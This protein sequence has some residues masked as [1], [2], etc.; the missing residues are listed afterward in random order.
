[1]KSSREALKKTEYTIPTKNSSEVERMS[2][3]ESDHEALRKWA[4]Q[5]GF[6][7]PEKLII[8]QNG[9]ILYAGKSALKQYKRLEEMFKQHRMEEAQN[10]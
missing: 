7:D 5:N 9:S 1:L 4:S 3:K 6:V 8:R 10:A 2:I